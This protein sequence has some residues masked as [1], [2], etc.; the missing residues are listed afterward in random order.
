MNV[1][2]YQ[3]ETTVIFVAA[4]GFLSA[5]SSS[6]NQALAE[7]AVA[8]AFSLEQDL[9]EFSKS[10]TLSR[11][12]RKAEGPMK[13]QPVC[14]RIRKEGCP[15]CLTYLPKGNN[16]IKFTTQTCTAFPKK[17]CFYVNKRKGIR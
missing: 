14:N 8:L 5:L 11:V 17:C 10:S 1:L 13:N 2:L 3:H 16:V 4:E 9:E 7:Q 6:E 15:C 12:T